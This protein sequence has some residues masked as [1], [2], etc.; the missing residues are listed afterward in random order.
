MALGLVLTSMTS[1]QLGVALS[2]GLVARI[3]VAGMIWLRLT[4]A[5]V[6]LVAIVRPRVRQ[7][8]RAGVLSAVALGVTSAVTA[9][10]FL[11]AVTRLPLGTV[12]AVEFLGPLGVAAVRGRTLR[13]ASWA[14][15]ALTGV[16][17]LTRPWTA[18]GADRV[19]MLLALMAAGGWAA[20]IV[21]IAGVGSRLSGLSGLA[22]S[23]PVAALVVA[24]F[25][26]LP[27]LG[28]AGPVD[29]VAGAGL[30]VLVP[31]VPFA[32]ELVALRR[33]PQQVFGVWMSLEPVIGLLVG[34]TV[35]AQVPGLDQ[36]G[37][38]LLVIAASIGAERSA[39]PSRP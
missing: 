31:L 22:V 4:W 19:G 37:G 26:A 27:V 20:Y 36:L 2:L 34:L 14:G 3:G 23:M 33:L 16:G 17:L 35:L 6:A 18:S 11:A 39:R 24:P 29:V 13:S 38:V 30:A 5:A 9:L 10:S 7:M 1:V 8:T 25:G 12:V 21:L 15:V 32:A 28:R